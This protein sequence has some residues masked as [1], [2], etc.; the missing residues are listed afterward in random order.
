MNVSRSRLL[1]FA[2]NLKSLDIDYK[3]KKYLGSFGKW[4]MLGMIEKKKDAQIFVFPQRKN[5]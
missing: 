4:K 5:E 3:H 2:N 1:L